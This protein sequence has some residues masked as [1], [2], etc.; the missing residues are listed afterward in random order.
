MYIYIDL[1]MYKYIYIDLC[2]YKYIYIYIMYVWIYDRIYL[3][4]L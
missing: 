1:C 3:G 2:M 4:K